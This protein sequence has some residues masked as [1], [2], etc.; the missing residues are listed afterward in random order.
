MGF[1]IFGSLLCL[2]GGASA[3]QMA[4]FSS[5]AMQ[6]NFNQ[7]ANRHPTLEGKG[8]SFNGGDGIGFR[9]IA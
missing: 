1:D 5:E 3:G 6:F 9:I 7:S 2:Y 8:I 4:K